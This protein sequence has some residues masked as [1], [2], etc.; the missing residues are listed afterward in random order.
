LEAATLPAAFF[1]GWF[2]AGA[3]LF[4]WSAPFGLLAILFKPIFPIYLH[5]KIWFYLERWAAV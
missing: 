2:T 1:F 4:G 3:F 5:R